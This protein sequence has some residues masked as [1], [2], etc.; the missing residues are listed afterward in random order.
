M[1]SG[2]LEAIGIRQVNCGVGSRIWIAG[3]DR[4]KSENG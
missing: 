1:A 2:R 4:L 3:L